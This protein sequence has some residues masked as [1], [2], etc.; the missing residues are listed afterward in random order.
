MSMTYTQA[1]TDLKTQAGTAKSAVASGLDD[2][3]DV[4]GATPAEA[5]EITSL[6]QQLTSLLPILLKVEAMQVPTTPASST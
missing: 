3:T 5:Q 6:V 4:A 2:L 1:I